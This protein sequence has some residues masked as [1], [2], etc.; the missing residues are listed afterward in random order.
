MSPPTFVFASTVK[1]GREKRSQYGHCLA[2]E[3]YRAGF[4]E[5]VPPEV[6][7]LEMRFHEVRVGPGCQIHSCCSTGRR[8]DSKAQALAH[9][10]LESTPG[11][12]LKRWS[13]V[14]Q[15]VSPSCVGSP[16]RAQVR[17]SG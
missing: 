12:E 14:L 10:G 2:Q 1:P 6:A 13:S 5:A 17:C 4:R 3:W 16:A 7:K 8:P 9:P 11:P 15:G